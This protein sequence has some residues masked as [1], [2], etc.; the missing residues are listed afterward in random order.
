MNCKKGDEKCDYLTL[1]ECEKCDKEAHI[2]CEKCERTTYC[3]KECQMKDFEVHDKT[4]TIP[5]YKEIG[6]GLRLPYGMELLDD[7]DLDEQYAFHNPFDM[8]CLSRPPSKLWLKAKLKTMEIEMYV[9]RVSE[10]LGK[11][12][13][14][15]DGI[16]DDRKYR[17]KRNKQRSGKSSNMSSNKSS[18]MS[19]NKSSNM[20]SNR[21]SNRSNKR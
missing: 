13:L 12:K 14:E 15:D 17:S 5:P 3:S 6:R 8:S 9:A 18:N 2:I 4:C 16:Q 10:V 21:S 1:F 7:K 20:S 19:S 11:I